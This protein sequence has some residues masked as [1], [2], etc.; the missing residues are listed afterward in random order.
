MEKGENTGEV[1]MTMMVTTIIIITGVINIVTSTTTMVEVFIPEEVMI[2]MTG[3]VIIE[4]IEIIL[5]ILMITIPIT[6]SI[7]PEIM[8]INL[9]ITRIPILITTTLFQLMNLKMKGNLSKMKL[10]RPKKE[11]FLAIDSFSGSLN[12]S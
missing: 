11:F 12:S 2:G 8:P 5:M 9:K 6:R 7:F 3:T 1:I 4:G 10:L